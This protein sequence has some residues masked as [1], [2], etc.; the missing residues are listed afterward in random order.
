MKK[1][2]FILILGLIAAF[3]GCGEEVSYDPDADARG[4]TAPTAVTAALNAKV[5][6]ELPFSDQQDFVECRQGFI[7]GDPDLRVKNSRGE[8]IWNQPA[9]GFIK[10]QAPSS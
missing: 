5:L 10:D 8:I 6:E 2:A 4:H 9:Y 7:A 3:N 1:R